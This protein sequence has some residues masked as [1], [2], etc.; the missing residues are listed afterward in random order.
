MENKS[1]ELV[2]VVQVM[3]VRWTR[4]CQHRTCNLWEFNPAKHQTL[5]EL[6]GSS[7]KDIWKV[8]F[9]SGKSWPDSAEDRGYQLSRPTSSVSYYTFYPHNPREMLNVFSTTLLGLDEEGGADPLSGPAAR[10][11]G[12]PTS[13]KDAGPD[14]LQGAEEEGREGGQKDPGRPSSPRCLGHNIRRLQ[15][16][17]RLRRERGGGGR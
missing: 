3:L 2:N 12:R 1:F 5:R 8:L 17:F 4:P 9:K 6:F 10:R 16:P 14:T 7:H 13:D 15:C 11:T